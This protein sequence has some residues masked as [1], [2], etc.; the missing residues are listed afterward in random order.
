MVAF[1][2]RLNVDYHKD[3]DDTLPSS[4]HTEQQRSFNLQSNKPNNYLEE[5]SVNSTRVRELM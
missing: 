4:S 5:V 1:N 2:N 3:A